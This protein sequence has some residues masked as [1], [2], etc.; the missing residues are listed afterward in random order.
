[1]EGPLLGAHLAAMAT[2]KQIPREEWQPYFERF[3]RQSLKGEPPEAA[4]IEVLSPTLGDQFETRTAR[5]DG[6]SYDPKSKAFEVAFEDPQVDH[7]VFE[8][9]EIWVMEEDWGFISTLELV[10]PDGLKEI[11]HVSRSGPP[12]PRYDLPLPPT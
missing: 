9:V 3:T 10:R 12:A 8:P 4:T 5:L 2:T 1:M 11:V 7:L 6:L